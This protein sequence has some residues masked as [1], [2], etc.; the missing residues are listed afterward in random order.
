MRPEPPPLGATLFTGLPGGMVEKVGV[1]PLVGG[2]ML[3]VWFVAPAA[4]PLPFKGS[5]TGISQT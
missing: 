1:A 4:L 5:P 2:A 3:M